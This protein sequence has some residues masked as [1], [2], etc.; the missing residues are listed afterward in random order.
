MKTKG[1]FL[2]IVLALSAMVV[3]LATDNAVSRQVSIL[4]F[5]LLIPLATL[6][7]SN[8]S[9]DHKWNRIEKLWA[10][11]SFTMIVSRYIIYAAISLL[12]SALW[13]LSPLH[14]G[15]MQNIADFVTLVLLTGAV[16]YPTMYL[17][18]SDHNLGLLFIIF[19]A[20]IGFI[21]LSRI[22]MLLDHSWA[23]GFNLVMLGMVCGFYVVS[24]TLSVIF[25]RFHMGRGV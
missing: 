10:V 11:S 24:L 17:L 22:A 6:N 23:D 7:A 4:V 19:S 8:V 25:N 9:F 21:A 16:Y 12:L 13:V 15:N 18:N 3:Y 14:D 5:L 2:C 20:V 1:M